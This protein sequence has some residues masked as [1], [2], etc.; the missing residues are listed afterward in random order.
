M[1]CCKLKTN[2][3]R[4]DFIDIIKSC[5][6]KLGLIAAKTNKSI[7]DIDLILKNDAELKSIVDSEERTY[8]AICNDVVGLQLE[9]AIV[10]GEQ[11]AIS[12]SENTDKIKKTEVTE[13]NKIINQVRNTVNIMGERGVYQKAYDYLAYKILSVSPF[14]TKAH[15]CKAFSCSKRTLQQWLVSFPSFNDYVDRGLSAGEAGARDMLLNSALDSSNKVNTTLL[16]VL[17]NNVYEIK[18]E[19]QTVVVDNRVDSATPITDDMT[20]KEAGRLY[21]QMIKDN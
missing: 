14:T 1:D 15:L 17:A 16:K 20:A 7:D 2:D 6:G 4:L 5:K 3:E 9:M 11:W 10:S 12:H 13:V 19:V 21:S 18:D 8:K